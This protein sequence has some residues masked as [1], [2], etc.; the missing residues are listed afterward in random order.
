MSLSPDWMRLH[1]E[2]PGVNVIKRFSSSPDLQQN[3]LEQEHYRRYYIQ[4]NDIH[5]NNK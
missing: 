3:K 2:S 1:A 5:H 4:H